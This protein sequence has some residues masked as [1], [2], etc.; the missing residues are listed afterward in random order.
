MMVKSAP[1]SM[2]KGIQK[3]GQQPT[4]KGKSNSVCVGGLSFKIL[5][6]F[7]RSKQKHKRN[8]NGEQEGYLYD[9]QAL[10]KLKR[11]YPLFKRATGGKTIFK[12]KPSFN[13][14]NEEKRTTGE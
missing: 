10:I 5:L 1:E 7:M 14:S 4:K 6:F 13:Q 3:T 8:N 11:E 12:A 2:N 9:L